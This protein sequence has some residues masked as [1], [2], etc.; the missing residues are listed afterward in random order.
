[1]DDWSNAPTSPGT[2]LPT[3]HQKLATDKE[4]SFSYS[5]Q[6][7]APCGHLDFGLLA[8]RTMSQYALLL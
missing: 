5:L 1:M 7:D 8:S 2:R 4:R 6:R 3:N